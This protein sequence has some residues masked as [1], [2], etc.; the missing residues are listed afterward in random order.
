MRLRRPGVTI[1]TADGEQL[2]FFQLKE[3]AEAEARNEMPIG[4][5]GEKRPA[6]SGAPWR[7]ERNCAWQ[8]N[9]KTPSALAL[10]R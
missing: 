6:D 5:K 2:N 9:G 1:E 10:V 7:T 8:I 3:M 4:R